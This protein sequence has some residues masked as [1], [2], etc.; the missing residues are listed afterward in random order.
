M[1]FSTDGYV[2]KLRAQIKEL[3]KLDRF[4]FLA[5]STVHGDYVERIFTQG[6]TSTLAPI[7]QYKPSTKRIREKRGRQTSFVN[8]TFTARLRTNIANS[9]QKVRNNFETG[10]TNNEETKKL[11]FLIKQYGAIVFK[12]SK[13]ERKKYQRIIQ[14]N[15]T[16]LMQS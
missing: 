12:A 3:K 6:R 8:L 10:T 7:G 9:L 15:F 4:I 11:G 16:Q 2:K 1:K 14:D 13:G 5:A